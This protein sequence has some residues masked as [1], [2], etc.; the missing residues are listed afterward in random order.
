MTAIAPGRDRPRDGAPSDFFD[1]IAHW[2]YGQRQ[3]FNGRVRKPIGC[4]EILP[5]VLYKL[6]T[7]I[8]E[9]AH[10]IKEKTRADRARR[11]RKAVPGAR[12]R[13]QRLAASRRFQGRVLG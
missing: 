13:D 5:E 9:A 7:A 11:R 2:Y 8:G 4:P 1:T 12:G 3:G 6:A 10:E